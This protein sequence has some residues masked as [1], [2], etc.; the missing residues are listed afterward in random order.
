MD[1]SFIK[2]II[3]LPCRIMRVLYR[4]GL[5]LPW[6]GFILAF[7][8]NA[9]KKEYINNFHASFNYICARSR[10]TAKNDIVE[11]NRA[12]HPF[13]TK[14]RVV[15]YPNIAF[16]NVIETIL[17]AFLEDDRFDVQVIICEQGWECP[18]NKKFIDLLNYLNIPW[19]TE[20]EF[21]N[22]DKANILLFMIGSHGGRDYTKKSLKLYRRKTDLLIAVTS[23]LVGNYFYDFFKSIGATDSYLSKFG[24]DVCFW[25]ALIYQQLKNSGC[26]MPH[27]V[28]MGNPKFDVI[29]RRLV[30]T[31]KV[32]ACWE[33]ISGKTIFLWAPDHEAMCN[34][35]TFDQYIVPV[36]QYF[37]KHPQAGLIF[38]PRMLYFDELQERYVLD[39]SYVEQLKS[40]FDQSPN[41][42]WDDL[43]DYS[44]SY[45]LADAIITD[46]SCGITVSALATGKPLCVF[47]RIGKKKVIRH[48]GLIENLYQVHSEEECTAFFDMVLRGEDPMKEKRE[49]AR[50]DCILHFDGKN[51]QRMKDFIVKKYEEKFGTLT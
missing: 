10:N 24:V 23:A 3:L 25:D 28:E 21:Q 27:C 22:E 7:R 1:F 49:R 20:A 41:L 42:I 37:E 33:R 4:R 47:F 36:L 6:R 19:K 9:V 16:W 2:K 46:V 48:P 30:E 29:Y 5:Y 38:R 39:R 43:P 35:C 51:G 40:Y 8:W 14:V 12:V 17:K 31:P 34:N 50:R 11:E 13:K 32:P 45:S 18:I 26:K 44:V 15:C